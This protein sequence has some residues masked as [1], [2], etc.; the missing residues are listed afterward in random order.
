MAI[1]VPTTLTPRWG[2]SPKSHGSSPGAAARGRERTDAELSHT[3]PPYTS[4]YTR[5]CLFASVGV[6][7]EEVWMDSFNGSAVGK[8][9]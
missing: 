8:M 1:G 7:Q 3:F 9:P 4:L 6:Q 5:A 2:G